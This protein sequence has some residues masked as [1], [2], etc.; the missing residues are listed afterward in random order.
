MSGF[1]VMNAIK[2]IIILV[3]VLLLISYVV[4]MLIFPWSQ[5]GWVY[6]QSVWSE[7][8][9]LN[10]GFLALLSSVIVLLAT[11]MQIY[12]QR[13]RDLTASKSLLPYT[14]SGIS[15]Y[16][17]DCASIVMDIYSEK[18]NTI[19]SKYRKPVLPIGSFNVMSDCIKNSDIE[20]AE[21]I[22]SIMTMLQVHH[23]RV[24]ALCNGRWSVS[25]TNICCLFHNM[26]MINSMVEELYSFS[27]AKHTAVAYEPSI[28]SIVNSYNA[29]DVE[30]ESIDGLIDYTKRKTRAV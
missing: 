14:L 16:L 7:W 10:A 12:E 15:S 4:C 2:F 8:Q 21:N 27:R 25:N 13:K 19:K 3:A 22:K 23:D 29:L 18:D 17:Y 1:L 26:A 30:Y 9:S 5:G 24:V 6:V 28:E 11:H 20:T